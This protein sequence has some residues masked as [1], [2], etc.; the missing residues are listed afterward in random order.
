[1]HG[2][3]ASP[4]DWPVFTRCIGHIR[5]GRIHGSGIRGRRSSTRAITTSFGRAARVEPGLRFARIRATGRSTS[6]PGCERSRKSGTPQTAVREYPASALRFIT[7]LRILS[8]PTSSSVRPYTRCAFEK[9]AIGNSPSSCQSFAEPGE[10]FRGHDGL[11][12]ETREN[13]L[14][15][16]GKVHGGAD[17]GEVEAIAAADI[18]VE[19]VARRGAPRRSGSAR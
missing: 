7:A 16:G 13:L 1:M 6:Q 18:A 10:A 15:P 17:A 2:L 8:S 5:A 19:D 4:S 12:Q 14:E 9:P 3:V 11:T